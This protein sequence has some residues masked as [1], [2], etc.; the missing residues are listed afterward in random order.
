[1]ITELRP[2]QVECLGAIRDSLRGGVKRLM[3]QAATGA[4][5]TKIAAAMVDSALSK[6]NRMAFVVPFVSLVDQ[7]VESFW[8]EGIR[9]VGVIQASHVLEDWSKPVQVCSIQTIQ[10]RGVFPQA[11]AVIFDEAHRLHETHKRWMADEAWAK[12]PFIGLSATPWAK[13]LGK[14]FESLLIAATTSDL[15]AQNYLSTFRVFATGHPDLSGVK[16]VAGDYHEGQ[17]SDAMQAGELT[18]DIIAT[19]KEK[20][21]KDKT[22]CFAVDK[23]HARS[24]Q[25]RFEQA[26]IRCGYQDASTTA[27]ERRELRRKFHSGEYRV[28]VNIQTLTTGVDW[29]VRCLILARPTKSEMMFCLDAETEILTSHGW[30]GIG[31]IKVGDCVAACD[32]TDV[33]SGK[34]SNVTAVVERD[35]DPSESWVE[36][37]APRANFRVTDRH[38]MI[39]RGGN[40]SRGYQISEAKEM[41]GRQSGVIVPTAISMKQAG[42]PLTDDEL[43]FI[44]MMMSDGTWTSTSGSI[45]QSERHP[46]IIE[47]IERCLQACRI[48]YAKRRVKASA[49]RDILERFPRWTFHFSAGKPKPHKRLGAAMCGNEVKVGYEFVSGETGYRHLIPYMDKEFAPTLFQMSKS[50]LLKFIG[51]LWDGDGSKKLGVDYTPRSLE[52]CS[53]RKLVVDRLQALC[54]INGMTANVRCENGASRKQPIYLITITD[55]DWRSCGGYNNKD[56]APRPAIEMKPATTEKVWCVESEA[57]TI[58]TRRRGKVTV[59]GNCQIVGRALRTAPGKDYALI[60]DHSDTTQRLGFVTDIHHE[61]LDDGSKASK[62]SAAGDAKKPL[63]KECKSCGCLKTTRVCPNC[64]AEPQRNVG[65]PIENDGELFEVTAGAVAKRQKRGA[66]S[67]AE[68]KMFFAEM[69]AYALQKGLK[70][71]WVSHKFKERYRDWPPRSFESIPAAREVSPVVA[72]WIK[73][74]NIAWAKS[75][76]RHAGAAS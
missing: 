12:V 53:A 7:T 76:R 57:G 26:G 32:G 21:G 28:V 44:G 29:D 41:A 20:W 30:K 59:M 40:D 48:G 34:W 39:F 36:Y 31:Q 67:E 75:R 51:G 43:Y 42:V 63:P 74:R 24:I 5:K 2:Y 62:L 14:H 8:A 23:A 72:G 25:D 47:R 64:G 50:Q 27:D 3:V 38:R 73:S 56:R 46:E 35:M 52:I 19:W 6:G 54:A 18:A 70:P 10:S 9:D 60:L 17:L 13:G 16:T 66:W 15:I 49:S 45:S 22:L 37:A 11:G 33:S 58:V 69:K 68:Q 55:K 65:G 4:G 1:M 71:G 61:R